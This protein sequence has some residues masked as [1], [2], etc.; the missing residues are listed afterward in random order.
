MVGM[1]PSDFGSRGK[2]IGIRADYHPLDFELP[3]QVGCSAMEYMCI[4]SVKGNLGRC[5][6]QFAPS[7]RRYTPKSPS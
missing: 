1:L 7:P 6:S 5:F 3:L 4:V 2:G